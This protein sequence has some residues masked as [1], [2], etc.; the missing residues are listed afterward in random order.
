MTFLESDLLV[1]TLSRRPLAAGSVAANVLANGCGAINIDASRIRTGDDLNGG[2]YNPNAAERHAGAEDWRFKGGDNGG[3]A[4]KTFTQPTGRWPANIILQHRSGCKPIG[5]K[6]IHGNHLDS[7]CGSKSETGIYHPR[8]AALKQGHADENGIEVVTDWECIDGCPIKVLDAQGGLTVSKGG[9]GTIFEDEVTPEQEGGISR[10]FKQV[11]G[12]VSTD[13]ILDIIGDLDPKAAGSPAPDGGDSSDP[14]DDLLQYLHTMITP[15][16]VGGESLIALDLGVVDWAA[17]PDGRYHGVI[18]R[19]EPTQEQVEHL[20]RIVKPG[21]HVLLIAPES[22]PTGH[23][24]ACTLEDKGFEIRD[25]ILWV[26]EAGHLHYVPKANTRERNAGCE[27]LAV[28]RK[29]IAIYELT[30]KALKDEELVGTISE[31]LTEAGVAEDVV[32]AMTENGILKDKIPDE[33]MQHFRKRVGGDKYGN[34]HPCVKPKDVMKRLLLDV[35]E[36]STVLDPFAGSGSMGIACLEAGYGY[37]GIE[38]ELEYGEVAVA[39]LTYWNQANNG[40]NGVEIK[41]EVPLFKGLAVDKDDDGI[42]DMFG[43]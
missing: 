27:A 10:Y 26:R 35:P 20:W 14:P 18:A 36:G 2:A 34:F 19:G 31:A 25:A 24:G 22:C 21:A 42:L 3:L 30:P 23:R 1:I 13:D 5:T 12:S 29:G 4:G 40:W 6:R 38:K 17:I 28:K 9:N 15:T 8:K 11:G 43:G 37:V 39:R 41:S 33:L 16:H 32:D 7:V